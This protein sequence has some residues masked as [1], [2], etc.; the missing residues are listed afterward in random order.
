MEV[1]KLSLASLVVKFYRRAEQHN[2]TMTNSNP[3]ITTAPLDIYCM[4]AHDFHAEK[5][6]KGC[7]L[8]KLRD[9]FFP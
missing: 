1:A 7:N 2:A 8:I 3:K 9:E 4:Y 5:C 6:L